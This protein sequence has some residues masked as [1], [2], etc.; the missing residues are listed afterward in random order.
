M[1]EEINEYKTAV[2]QTVEGINQSVTNSLQNTQSVISS[3][4]SVK[5][6]LSSQSTGNSLSLEDYDSDE[7]KEYT[8]A[9]E[10]HNGVLQLN[11]E[12]VREIVKAKSEEQIETN[13]TN[14][15]MAQSTYLENAA[16]IEKLRQEIKGKTGESRKSIQNE[17]NALL[18]EN[19]AIKESCD[20]YDLMTASLQEATDAYHNWLNAQNA[21]QSGDMFDDA[22]NAVNRINE[23]LNKSESEYYG[24]VGRSDYQTSLELIIP[25][26]VDSSDKEKVNSYL[27]SIYDLFTY[28]EDGNYAGLNIENF[29]Q[30]AVDK[31]LMVFDKSK[32]SYKIA[33]Q[34]TMEDFA[35][36]LKLSMPIVQAA[37][38]EMEEFGGK[39]S[40]A[41]EAPKTI[42]DLGVAANEAAESLRQMKD[43][44]NLEI[45][46][47][48]SDI[49]DSD[50][51]ILT[52]ETTI[53]KMQRIK[54]KAKVDASE[55]EYAN[56]I[57]EYCVAQQ[58]SLSEPIVMR[59][60]TSAISERNSEA[61][62][63]IQN[64]QRAY[65][66]LDLKKALGVD[67]SDANA[68]VKEL[69][70]QV[71]KIDPSIR[72]QLNLD[73]SSVKKLR[74]SIKQIGAEQLVKI[75]IDDSAIDGWTAN[76]KTATVKYDKDTTEIDSYNPKNLERSVTYHV[77][78]DLSGTQALTDY[79]NKLSG[80]GKILGKKVYIPKS[81]GN[82]NINGTAMLGGNWGAKQ[83]GKTLTGELG[84]EI[85]VDPHTG[86]WYTVGDNGAEFVDIPKGAVVFN[87]KQT[88]SLLEN[89]YV[90]G[91]ASAL[92]N[93]TAMVT[94]GISH[95]S[96][97]T[98]SKSGGNSTGNYGKSS[99][100]KSKSKS[101]KNKKSSKSKSQKD[102]FEETFD[103]VEVAIDR[104][105]RAI[106]NLDLKASSV[107]KSWSTRNKSLTKE[108]SKVTKEINVQQQGYNKYINQANSVGLSKS[109]RKKVK[110]GI[111]DID[112]IKNE[113]LADKIKEYQQWYEKALECKDAVRQLRE[114]EADLYKQ[115]FDNVVTKY[116]GILAFNEQK[117]NM[118]NEQISQ[119]EEKG[120]IVS[121]NYYKALIKNEQNSISTMG[122]ERTALINKL[123]KA[124][125]N[126]KITVGSEAYNEMAKEINEVSLSIAEANTNII[127]YNNSIRDIDWQI[128]DLM[129]EKIS[130]ISKETEFLIDLISSKKLYDNKGQ[131]TDE[132]WATMSLYTT[133]YE[134]Y[135]QQAREYAKELSDID[136]QLKNDPYNQHLIDRREELL[137]LQQEMISSA[138]DEKQAIVDMVEEGINLELDALKELID[139]YTDALDAQKDLYDYQKKISDQTKDITSLQKQLSAYENDMSE[140]TKSKIQQIKVSLE[141]AEE[142]LE[143]AE[144]DQYI[145]DQKNLLDD[146]YDEYEE[147]LNTR[148]DNVD[149]LLSDMK[150]AIDNNKDVI[151]E[152]INKAASSVGYNETDTLKNALTNVSA[153]IS[154]ILASISKMVTDSNT[155]ANNSI[156]STNATITSTPTSSTGSNTV[157]KGVFGSIPGDSVVQKGD[158]VKFKKGDLH[159]TPK[160]GGG[161]YENKSDKWRGKE[162][163]VM[164][165][166]SAVSTDFPYLLGT[167]PSVDKGTQL[168]WVKKS[169]ISG[170]SSGIKKIL[171]DELAW[172]QE[173]KK[174]E[175][176]IRPSDGA[177]LT[178]LARNDSILNAEATSN[179][180][181]FAN[182]P[183]KF[184]SDSILSDTLKRLS[185]QDLNVDFTTKY[186]SDLIPHLSGLTDISNILSTIKN[187]DNNKDLVSMGDININIPI[188]HVDDYN[189]FVT[190]L[191]Q[192]KRFEKLIN[193]FSIDPLCKGDKYENDKYIWR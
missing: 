33:G 19:S 120:Y 9:L 150:D 165:V 62:G 178:P 58:Q 76:N 118:L 8:S 46:L 25:D 124:V 29:C 172:T 60:D 132:G 94:G 171:K 189:D 103:W 122:K 63:L 191:Q 27:K 44:K 36:G 116:D 28:D 34:K 148:L 13:N 74:D 59:V 14:K 177:V 176:I 37:F 175:A 127:E 164:G 5:D 143:E 96:T 136:N 173:G 151:S 159:K 53:K 141:E 52:L 20:S 114:Q 42:G 7:L 97:V 193:S 152:A 85:V 163:Y 170:Y 169:Q 30:K 57:I 188:E 84:R 105:E 101:S 156:A 129:Q 68:K 182:N 117:A 113:K 149:A 167:N 39:F 32:D 157:K 185:E 82:N 106:S 126:G 88:E 86:K 67:T 15:A 79:E 80:K 161:K 66:D 90:A 69:A 108:I 102:D 187:Q 43:Y 181:E 11:A 95:N 10:Y 192:D 31:G 130:Q 49:D 51:K 115:R 166:N 72:A 45:R 158:K 160:K 35:E 111:I 123:N 145:S 89:G 99:S 50:T 75:G 125:N 17:I 24:R 121:G 144:Y 155:S 134:I 12:K 154:S 18:E 180:F 146:L 54:G 64:F 128:F 138:E 91:R 147:I 100:S 133:N 135:T 98:S 107:Y 26:S 38:G 70:G 77:K 1:Q 184:I 168:G 183:K 6:A 61:I 71:K 137:E 47:D 190:K 87:H 22:L 140:E 81:S 55:V 162:L 16:K 179:L 110:D 174:A 3:I 153:T 139:S 92:I 65:N 142:G 41:D 73:T 2:E 131:L 48:V 21:S 23:T 78:V 56:Q 40:W 112:T 83:G 104:V 109:W 4:S 119:T 93:G 186:S